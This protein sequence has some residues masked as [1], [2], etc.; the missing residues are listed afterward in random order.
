MADMTMLLMYSRAHVTNSPMI[1]VLVLS[2]T[3]FVSGSGGRFC[4]HEIL[5][6]DVAGCERNSVCIVVMRMVR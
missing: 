5:G 3:L 2:R 6:F 4:W 1:I